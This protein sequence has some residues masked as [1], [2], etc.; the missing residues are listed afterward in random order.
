M[1]D[2]PEGQRKRPGGRSERVR[3]AVMDATVRSLLAGGTEGLSIPQV[4]VEAGVA[5][6]TIYRRWGDPIHLAAE[7]MTELVA[8]SV[9]VQPTGDLRDDLINLLEQITAIFLVPG[10]TGILG[11]IIVLAEDERIARARDA[12]WATR[13]EISAAIIQRAVEDGALPADTVAMEL[14]ELLV[15]PVYFRIGAGLP[16]DGF[17]PA[18]HTDRVLLAFAAG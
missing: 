16:L 2:S 8:N 17:S 12:F 7:A 15:G 13:F 11:S 18:P 6:S 14:V 10:M 5:E 4:A 9:P 3:R 1:S